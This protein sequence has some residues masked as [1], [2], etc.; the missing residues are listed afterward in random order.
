MSTMSW[1]FAVIVTVPD[2]SLIPSDGVDESEPVK[3]KV[4][5]RHC[6]TMA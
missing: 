5:A 3:L 4:N 2:T 6:V 1:T